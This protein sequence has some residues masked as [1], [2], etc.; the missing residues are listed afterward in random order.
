MKLFNFV[1]KLKSD[2]DFEVK[3]DGECDGEGP[4]S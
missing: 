3:F 2:L 1:V 4:E